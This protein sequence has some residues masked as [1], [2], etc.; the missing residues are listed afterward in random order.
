[1]RKTL[2]AIPVA[3]VLTASIAAPA[4]SSGLLD[5]IKSQAA[6]SL[7]GTDAASVKDKLM[8]KVGLGSSTKARQDSGYQQGLSGVLSGDGGSSFSLAK[9]KDSL[10]KKVCDYVLNNAS[11][12]L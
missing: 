6:G 9:V 12:L 10:K 5:T 11:S 8:D 1:M 3:A 2:Y 7:G 4:W